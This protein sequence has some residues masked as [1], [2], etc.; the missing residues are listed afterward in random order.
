MSQELSEGH[1]TDTRRNVVDAI[2]RSHEGENRDSIAFE[3]FQRPLVLTSAV[4]ISNVFTSETAPTDRFDRSE[5]HNNDAAWETFTRFLH[6][7]RS[8]R[9]FVPNHE[10]RYRPPRQAFALIEKRNPI[11][12]HELQVASVLRPIRD[13]IGRLLIVIREVKAYDAP[14]LTSAQTA[15]AVA[16]AAAAAVPAPLWPFASGQH[17]LLLEIE[18]PA[19][20]TAV[21]L[22]SAVAFA[23]N[24]GWVGYHAGFQLHILLRLHFQGAEG[25]E[26]HSS[27]E[28]ETLVSSSHERLAIWRLLCPGN[29]H[30]LQ[31]QKGRGRSG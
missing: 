20:G 19:S 28:V 21:A 14:F 10:L 12:R 7:D 29:F 11:F 24:T 16:H 22:H 1:T 30:R 3:H 23:D 6:I 5:D 2:S 27:H 31:Y 4:P 18:T 26:P 25:A 17:G 8:S 9:K 13:P 15:R